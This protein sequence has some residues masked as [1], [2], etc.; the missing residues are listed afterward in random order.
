MTSKM[1]RDYITSLVSKGIRDDGRKLLEYRKPMTVEYGVSPK[2]AEGSAKVQIGETEVV[3]GVKMEVM[4]PFPDSPDEGNLM[5]NVELLPLSNPEFELGPPGIEAIELAR[6]VDRAIRESKCVDMKKLCIKKGEKVWTV[7]VDIYPL[8]DNGNLF[9]ACALAA[10]A[11]VKDAKFPHYDEKNDKIDYTKKTEK[12]LPIIELPASVTVLK[13]KDSFLIDPN[14]EETQ[15]YDARLTV[16]SLKD[17]TICALQKG[18][19]DSFTLED[20]DKM[21]DIGIDKGK[22]FRKVLEK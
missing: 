7:V 16:A 5:V 13:I 20:I 15:I 2:S 11:A 21:I 17:G 12:K 8:N 19:A 10:L 1:I 3:A 6:V 18:G 4:E 9:D 22:E 14:Y